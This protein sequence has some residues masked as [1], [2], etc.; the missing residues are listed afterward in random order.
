MKQAAG[1]ISIALTLLLFAASSKYGQA[2]TSI[3]GGSSDNVVRA[4]LS[5]EDPDNPIG[6]NFIGTVRWRVEKTDSDSKSESQHQLRADI[7]IPQ[8]RLSASIAFRLNLDQTL[9]ASHIAELAFDLPADS[10]QDGVATVRGILVKQIAGARGRAIPGVAA[11]LR[12]GVFAIAYPDTQVEETTELLYSRRWLEI[13]MIFVNGRRALLEIDKDVSG[14]AAFK[15]AFS[16][17]AQLNPRIAQAVARVDANWRPKVD[18]QPNNWQPPVNPRLE[19]FK[20]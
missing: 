10:P 7:V 18:P 15:Q 9:P 2:Q 3:D 1:C 6:N 14:T 5:E 19:H 4:I 17:W 16:A 13:A 11:K 8:R 20:R 12:P